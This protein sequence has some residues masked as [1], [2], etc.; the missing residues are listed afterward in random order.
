MLQNKCP[1]NQCDQM[2]WLFDQHLAIYNNE[3][4]PNSKNIA[5]ESS[6]ICQILNTPSKIYPNTFK[7]LPNLVTLVGMNVR[8]SIVR[9]FNLRSRLSEVQLQYLSNTNIFR[10]KNSIII[11]WVPFW[12]G[13]GCIRG[14]FYH[15]IFQFYAML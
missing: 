9:L 10:S 6:K 14:L 2:A 13:G 1:N 11:N 4:L 12:G 7:M 15:G 5:I 3:N 8:C